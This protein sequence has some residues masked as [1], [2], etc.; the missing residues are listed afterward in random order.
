[1]VPEYRPTGQWTSLAA[2]GGIV[3]VA[4]D[5][6]MIY[7]AFAGTVSLTGYTSSAPYLE[8]HTFD[9]CGGHSSSSSSPSYHY[10]TAPSCLLAQL[11][12]TAGAHSPQ[13]QHA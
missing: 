8:G 12:Q 11:G 3:G 13:V 4:F 2:Q 6:A 10:H 1:M 7:S 9:S 5:G